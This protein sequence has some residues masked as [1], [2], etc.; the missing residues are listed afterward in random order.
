[1][2]ICINCGTHNDDSQL[3]CCMCG[4]RLSK[5]ETDDKSE[6]IRQKM[7][8]DIRQRNKHI[9]IAVLV[10][11]FFVSVL[12]LLVF[13]EIKLKILP[14]DGG[15]ETPTEVVEMYLDGIMED[16]KSM[17]RNSI[18]Y[19]QRPPVD[20]EFGYDFGFWDYNISEYEII[21]EV[22]FTDKELY[23]LQEQIRE[24]SD[25][26]IKIKDAKKIYFYVVKYEYNFSLLGNND[27]YEKVNEYFEAIAVKCQDKWFL[28]KP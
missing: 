18:I 10:P 19:F 25:T 8:N 26:F 23:E 13:L 17:Y 15:G 21:S 22:N 14:L 6:L 28:Y 3:Q 1:M 16:K 4:G 12:V 7:K 9:A 11:V 20:F 27:P 24:D 5:V 2:K